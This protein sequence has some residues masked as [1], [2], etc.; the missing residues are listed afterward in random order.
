M[1]FFLYQGIFYIFVW[2]LFNTTCY[3]KNSSFSTPQISM[4]R[5]SHEY[6]TLSICLAL[7]SPLYDRHASLEGEGG[8][9]WIGKYDVLY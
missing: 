7:C 1:C 8:T 2:P 3:W 5:N 6:S 4:A 9:S